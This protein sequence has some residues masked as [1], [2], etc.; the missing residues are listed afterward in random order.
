MIVE[1]AL[2]PAL[3]ANWRDYR[4]FI[5]QFGASKGR[6]IS[7]DPKRWKRMV[8]EAAQASGDIEFAKITESLSNIDAMLL[9]RFHEWDRNHDWLSN[10]VIEHQRRPFHGIIARENPTGAT[11][12]LCGD[13]LDPADPSPPE[14]WA[15]PTSIQVA[16]TPADLA[17][18]VVLLLR[19]CKQILFIDP[20]YDPANRRH[21]L[22]L[23]EFLKIIASRDSQLAAP[24]R[25]EYHTS[26]KNRDKAQFAAD[27]AR[28][29]QPYL[30]PKSLLTIVRWNVAELHN[31]YIISDRGGVMF[32]H[33]LDQDDS[34]PTAY[35]T[36]SLLDEKTCSELLDDYSAQSTKLTW[37]N[38]TFP[39]TG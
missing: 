30:P 32:G 34:I 23:Q 36:I 8:L 38:D 33:G 6:L 27:L 4:Y 1:F 10:A 19:H 3:I 31:R 7:R 12:V 35:D 37:L 5:G 21:N 11:F 16:R 25:M 13:A 18:C 29:V 26:N 9:T 15:I 2:E 20:H 24:I 22:P 39:V 28:W 14:I 17:S